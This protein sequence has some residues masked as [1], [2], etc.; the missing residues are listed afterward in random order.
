M[1]AHP[2]RFAGATY[3][4]VGAVFDQH[5]AQFD[6][7]FLPLLDNYHPPSGDDRAA[8]SAARQAALFDW[9]ERL[10]DYDELRRENRQA[11]P[12]RQR[13][14]L[15]R[16]FAAAA[17][18]NP[19]DTL[20]LLPHLEVPLEDN[21]LVQ[22]FTGLPALLGEPELTAQNL[23]DERWPIRAWKAEGSSATSL[24]RCI[25]PRS[26]RP[27]RT[28]GPPTILRRRATPSGNDNLTRFV[29]DALVE[30][31]DPRRYRDLRDLDNGLR[32]RARRA[33]LAY[34]CAMN[35]V[36]LPGG[37]TRVT[38]GPPKDL[39]DLLL[40]DVDAGLCER[41]SRID[42]AVTAVQAFVERALL[43]P[44]A[45]LDLGAAFRAVWE[46][47]FKTFR[48]W[49]ACKRR[50]LYPENTIECDELE[51]AR[52]DEAFRLLEEKLRQAAL[53]VPVPAGIQ[54]WADRRPPPQ[55]RADGPAG[56]RA[57]DTAPADS[58]G[59]PPGRQ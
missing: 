24:R 8:P 44:R 5:Q 47:R 28:G 3:H 43:R 42:D 6:F 56:G 22:R 19:G 45:R 12:H 10:F 36:Q 15:W 29:G 58:G 51:R 57:V 16:L 41:A 40:L 21:D 7:N 31:G 11:Q 49:Q 35:R 52:R 32:E 4:R 14:R 25:P 38:P 59:H 34:L 54:Y 13:H 55:L 33:L 1:L 17:A 27:A 53:S 2:D 39:S 30:T 18:A 48:T 20:Q 37:R 23:L 46:G 50:E 9:W 26:P